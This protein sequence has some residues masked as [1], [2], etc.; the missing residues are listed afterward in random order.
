LEVYGG[1]DGSVDRN[2]RDGR[3]L[4]KQK[5][6]GD[7]N[8]SRLT[9]VANLSPS[10]T[11]FEEKVLL[12]IN[13]AVMTSLVMFHA[14]QDILAVSDESSVSIWSLKTASRIM[15]VKNK[16]TVERS[17][18]GESDMVQKIQL[19]EHSF[20][21]LAEPRITSM[22]W[23]NES[24]NSLLLLGSDDGVVKVWKDVSTSASIHISHIYTYNNRHNYTPYTH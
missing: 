2:D 16:H 22:S 12:T 8:Q 1:R 10:V 24:Y 21:P 6:G 7:E 20:R 17:A 18:Y 5:G 15:D 13:H 11:K 14:Y 4:N 19:V 3:D 9:A 23:I